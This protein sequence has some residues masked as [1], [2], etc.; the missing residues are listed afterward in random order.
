MAMLIRHK[1]TLPCVCVCV[2][3]CICA[4]VHAC[5]LAYV[6]DCV[7]AFVRDCVRAFVRDCVRVCVRAWTEC[8]N[9]AAKHTV[10]QFTIALTHDTESQ[11][12]LEQRTARA[13]LPVLRATLP[14]QR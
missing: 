4:C 3:A 13:C 8:V 9:K 10:E 14:S 12:G 5:V 6:R 1:P 11:Y 2:R 7:R